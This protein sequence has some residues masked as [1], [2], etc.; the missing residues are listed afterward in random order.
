MVPDDIVE[1]HKLVKKNN[2]EYVGPLNNITYL[3]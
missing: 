2:I 1:L 3:L